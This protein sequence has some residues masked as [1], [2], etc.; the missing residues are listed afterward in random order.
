MNSPLPAQ[1]APP[2]S[3]AVWTCPF[4][5]LLCDGFVPDPHDPA[6]LS[7]SQCP[8]AHAALA[9]HRASKAG[10]SGPSVDGVPCP[11]DHAVSHAA[12]L[13]SQWRQPLFGGLGT[14]VAGART[15]YRLAARCGAVCDH[16]DGDALMHGVRATQDRG[17]FYTTLGEIRSRADVVVCVGT[18]AVA[19]YPEFFRRCGFGA[20][21]SPCRSLVFLGAPAPQ[22]VPEGVPVQALPGTGDLYAD[23]QQLAALVEGRRCRL[24]DDGLC[25][26]AGQLR[27]ARYAVLVWE[28]GVLPAHGMLVVEA[29]NRIVGN[30]NR[31]TRAAT[32]SLGG[33]EGAY[34]V[35]QVFTWMSGLPLRTRAG[36]AGLEHEPLRF[37]ATRLIGGRAVDGL[38]WISSFD[39]MRLPPPVDLPL[40]VLGPPAMALR[41]HEAGALARCVFVPVATPG[42]NAGGHLFRTDGGIVVP[43]VPARDDGLPAV[44]VVL[45]AM[46]DR[47]AAMAAG[48]GA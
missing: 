45:T 15:L 9:A 42:L 44:A 19:R 24:P 10:A 12:S 36:P 48:E 1:A 28:A 27:A 4:C 2:S 30:L 7:G 41:L 22:E 5:S 38:L 18:P 6:R 13:L 46:N 29:L 26:L 43:L 35:N 23:V 21:D 47:M 14:D 17:Q 39:P 32:F 11:M 31:S 37:G 34:T 40:I 8:R 16:A 25:A 3:L 33:S 20:P